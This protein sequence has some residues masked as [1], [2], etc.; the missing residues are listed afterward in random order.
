MALLPHVL[1]VVGVALDVGANAGAITLALACV[2]SQGH[3]V[4]FEVARA[5]ADRLVANLA[6]VGATHARVERVAVY[7]RAAQLTLIY[8]EESTGG[9]S[10]STREDFTAERVE[11]ITLDDWAAATGGLARLDL[12]KIDVEGSRSRATNRHQRHR[13]T[14]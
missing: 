13:R 6:R 2:A 1:P 9:A 4:A 5:N 3:V 8:S 10:V 11:S 14:V 7:D 12:V